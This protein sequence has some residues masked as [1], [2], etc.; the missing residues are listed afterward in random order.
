[1]Q[2]NDRPTAVSFSAITSDDVRAMSV[3]RVNTVAD[4]RSDKMGGTT[5]CGTC[6]RS[7]MEC[8]G[9]FGHIELPISIT[10]PLLPQ[11]DITAVPVPP[12][13]MRL[14]NAEHD[15]PLTSLLNRI[16]RSVDR[17]HR[18]AG[19]D[20]RA[21]SSAAQGLVQS[22][23]AYYTSAGSTGAQGLCARMR[24]KGGTLRQTLMGWRVN[25]CARAVVAPDP[26]LAPWEVGVPAS[27][28][29]VLGVADGASVLLN[30]QP[31]LHRGA[32]MG[33]VVRIR[34]SDA[35][36]SISPTVTPPYNADFD[37]DEMNMHACTVQ[38]TADARVLLGVENNLLSPAG[39]GVSVRLVQDACLSWFLRSGLNCQQQRASILESCEAEGSCKAAQRLHAE[40]LAAHDHMLG[41]GFSVGLDDMLESIPVVGD[42]AF[43]LG[44]VAAAA[45]THVRASNRIAQMVA[46]GSKGSTVNLA[47]L[48]GCIGFQTVQGKPAIHP[49][50]GSAFIK[51]SF[52]TGMTPDEFWMHASAA[53]EGMIQTAV[54]T[55]D[56]GYLMR[57][58]VKTLENIVIAYDGTVRTASG[59]VVQFKYG[60]D[61]VDTSTVRYKKPRLA[62]PGEPVGIVCAQSIGERLTQLTLDTFHRA[63]LAFK[64]GI[65]RV[66][67]LL[68]ATYK[69]PGLLR[70]LSMP[71]RLVRYALED[72]IGQWDYVDTLP[73]RAQMEM[74]LR[75]MNVVPRHRAT[76]SA[77]WLSAHGLQLWHVASRVREIC[78]CVSDGTYLYAVQKASGS[79]GPA[80]AGSCVVDGALELCDTPPVDNLQ[81]YVSEP[82]IVA[83]TLGIEAA[84][85]VL[86][87]E[88]IPY[89]SGVDGRHIM[90][91]A[92]AMTHTGELLGATRSGLKRADAVSVL[93]RAC[94]ETGPQILAS[95]AVTGAVDP[96]YAASSRLAMGLVPRVGAHA[97]GIVK[98]VLSPVRERPSSFMDRPV[99]KRG[100]FGAYMNR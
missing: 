89:V 49:S 15:A 96:L 25:S 52:V 88:L 26:T 1:M 36:I 32:I 85:A 61:G 37:G 34:A 3:L 83:A 20:E 63:G 73:P 57:R 29:Q 38:S 91:L 54:K 24:G 6:G 58:M 41:R 28:A 21:R 17:Y 30:R 93:G 78:P 56:T 53:R 11:H 76:V 79:S 60:G 84:A 72:A 7:S 5:C 68:D 31:S 46:A 81:T 14:P 18:C 77:S 22:V 16:I 75:N 43:T 87:R 82:A 80:W 42:D 66:R 23:T 10:H 19:R 39:G 86:Q 51:N 95:A 69:T 99:A 48:F 64:Y 55:A 12:T 90:L 35:C 40:Q 4:L 71:Y 50:G 62:E 13:R 94:F 74:R 67:S 59:A 44:S 8:V 9:H 2:N 98:S 33:H 47:Q 92:D 27:I 100:R 65:H 70:G 97:F 45:M